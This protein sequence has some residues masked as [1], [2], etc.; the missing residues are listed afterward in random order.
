MQDEL[1]KEVS[2][3]GVLILDFDG[4]PKVLLMRVR[5]YGYELPK[6]HPEE[7]ESLRKAAIREFKEETG[8]KNDIIAKNLLGDIIYT[9]QLKKQKIRKKV[10]YF[11]LKINSVPEFGEKPKEVREIKWFSKDEIKEIPVVNEKLRTII[12]KGFYLR[13]SKG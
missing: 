8:L 13:N 2:S 11:L 6:G 4:V 1:K 12:Y 5:S 10:Y 7:E 3:G 9:F